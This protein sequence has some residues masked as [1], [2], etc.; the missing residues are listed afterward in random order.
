MSSGVEEAEVEE[1]REL[2]PEDQQYKAKYRQLKQEFMRALET[3]EYVRSE[4][5]HQ[6]KLL[7]VL[8]EDKFFL[9]ERM[10]GHEKPPPSPDS[11]DEA[12]DSESEQAVAEKKARLTNGGGGGGG[13]TIASAF[14]KIK[15]L[16]GR[17]RKAKTKCSD[18]N[19]DSF[20]KFEDE[21]GGVSPVKQED[22]E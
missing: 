5:R 12:S 22:S 4:L 10:L 16:T 14:S 15:S 11:N 3:H 6:Q 20:V 19:F 13:V 7:H 1:G 8:T 9:L 18:E 17:K 21:L 2:D